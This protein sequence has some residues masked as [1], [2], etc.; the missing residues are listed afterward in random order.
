MPLTGEA[1]SAVSASL[2]AQGEVN[3]A[4]LYPT[5]SIIGTHAGLWTRT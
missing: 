1:A 4:V 5:V 2:C 3:Q